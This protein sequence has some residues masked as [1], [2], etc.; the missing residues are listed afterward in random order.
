LH[1]KVVVDDISCKEATQ[2]AQNNADYDFLRPF[3]QQI[4]T[5]LVHSKEL[6]NMT[7]LPHSFL[8]TAPSGSGKSYILNNLMEQMPIF[9]GAGKI[10]MVKGSCSRLS[11]KGWGNFSTREV[12]SESM[13]DN[14]GNTYQYLLKIIS[15]LDSRFA[16]YTMEGLMSL[17]QDG[18]LVVIIDDMDMVL[19]LFIDPEDLSQHS[20][21]VPMNE[22]VRVLKY[23]G[24]YLQ[25]MLREMSSSDQD[26][27][28]W[29]IGASSIPANKLPRSAKGSP[30]F[31]RVVSVPKPSRSD[32]S[33]IAAAKFL[34]V[35]KDRDITL[36][37]S[38]SDLTNIDKTELA[39]QWADDLAAITRGYLPADI[40][41]VVNRAILMAT[42]NTSKLSQA[43]VLHMNWKNILDA[44]A[45]VP[46][47][48]LQNIDFLSQ[49]QDYDKN[50]TWEDFAGYTESIET[51]KRFLRPF[52][53]SND[54]NNNALARFKL[55]RGMVLHGPS[56][57][58]KT[59]L[60]KIIAK[61]VSTFTL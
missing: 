27:R 9:I 33:K 11:T 28:I 41:S 54:F 42:G 31:E 23:F 53:Q 17:L 52:S 60:A 6:T 38:T 21:L 10:N 2:N 4:T 18:Q 50:Y 47:K 20:M 57:C 58:G 14:H 61:Q 43:E 51:V 16:A 32:R 3:L 59:L 8:L 55:P 35:F 36:H 44:V 25:H 39:A 26:Y 40:Q 29:V 22:E 12:H 45:S 34:S 37:S 49:S 19:R 46:L 15:A 48:T 13:E 5:C 1:E 7:L 24:Y 56:G 30:E